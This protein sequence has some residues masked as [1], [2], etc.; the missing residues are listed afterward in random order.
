M[1]YVLRPGGGTEVPLLGIEFAPARLEA[2]QAFLDGHEL[3]IHLDRSQAPRLEGIVTLPGATAHHEKV[4]V[5]IRF[6][7]VEG[8]QDTG[9]GWRVQIPLTVV[10]WPPRASSKTFLARVY[11][12]GA[13]EIHSSFPAGFQR[14]ELPG[15]E[16]ASV[17]RVVLPVIPS[18]LRFTASPTGR[19]GF[20]FERAVDLAAVVLLAGFAILGWHRFRR[21]L[22]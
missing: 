9:S 12:D 15:E 4:S 21:L 1:D 20:T 19:T 5:R 2:M 14:V 7:V 17:Y 13:A 10:N 6:E 11:L 8:L 16:G 22:A 18:M 3:E